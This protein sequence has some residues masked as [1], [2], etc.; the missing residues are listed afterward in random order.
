V[1]NAAITWF[2]SDGG[3]HVLVSTT[4]TDQNGLS[5]NEIRDVTEGSN[6]V[7]AFAPGADPVE[8]TVNV[9]L[10]EPPAEEE[11]APP[12]PPALVPSLPDGGGG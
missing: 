10:Y 9:E 6:V 8:F 11:P 1:P 4:T 12:V 7:V 5:T 3:G 2:V